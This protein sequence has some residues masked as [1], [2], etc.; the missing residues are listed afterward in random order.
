MTNP[1][2]FDEYIHQHKKVADDF[3]NKIQQFLTTQDYF[4]RSDS[5]GFVRIIPVVVH[6]IHNGGTENISDAQIISQIQ[7]LNEDYRKIPFTNGDGNGVDTEV[8]FCLANISPNGRCTN[9]IVRVQSTLTTHQT[10]QGEQMMALSHWDPTRYLNIY[11]VKIINGGG[12]L[13]YASFPGGPPEGDGI[14]MAHTAFGT[15]GTAIAPNNL[16]RTT[17]HE[18]GHWFGLYHT[19]NN[20]CGT[21]TCTDGDYVCDTPPVASPNF[22]CPVINSCS[23]DFP[24]INDQIENYLDYT[25]DAC[26]SMFTDGQRSRMHATL[27]T[28]RFNIWQ[29][30]NIWST[31]CDS[32]Y[33]PLP[34]PAVADFT[35]NGQTICVGNT[36]SFINRSLNNCTS[37]QWY[38][39]GGTPSSSTLVNPTVMYN[40][41]G[42]YNVELVATNING[43]DSVTFVNYISVVTPQVGQPLPFTEGFETPVFPPNGITIDNP[44]A[45]ITWEKDTVAVQYGGNGSAKINNLINTNYGQA[46]ALILPTLDL[47]SSTTPYLSFRWAYAKSDPSYSDELSVQISTDCGVNFTQIFY[48]TGAS[49]ITGPTQATPYIPDSNTIWKLANINLTAYATSDHAIIKVINVTDGGNALYVDNINIDEVSVGVAEIIDPEGNINVYPNPSMGNVTIEFNLLESSNVLLNVYDCVGRDVTSQKWMFSQKGL[50]KIIID[51]SSFQGDGIYYVQLKF[52][53]T[54]LRRKIIITR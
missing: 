42:T 6:V 19:F 46:D 13:G 35:S 40:T 48:R 10:T 33:T 15:L 24:D 17:T 25:N 16:G 36:V 29:Y 22:G 8:Q 52:E 53:N 11:V 30:S 31:G 5:S 47:T 54:I 41:L 1:C 50:N 20:G 3:E 44:D 23:N 37:Y 9:G 12:I 51:G 4:Q 38:F 18:S 14:V 39:P 43:T 34:C 26:K 45:G 49:M 2:D 32:G 21:D 27:M 7:V 28:E